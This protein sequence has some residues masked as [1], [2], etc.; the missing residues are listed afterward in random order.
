MTPGILTDIDAGVILPLG[1]DILRYGATAMNSSPELI[2]LVQ[3]DRERHIAQD[4]VARILACARACCST[5]IV[6]RVARA[7]RLTPTSC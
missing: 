3:A 1:I 2:A 5:S 7:L 4:R 6:D